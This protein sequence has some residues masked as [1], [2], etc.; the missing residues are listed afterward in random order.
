MFDKAKCLTEEPYLP[1]YDDINWNTL[2]EFID[3]GFQGFQ[4]FTTYFSKRIQKNSA[5]LDL[6]K[7]IYGDN[8]SITAKRISSDNAYTTCNDINYS[9]ALPCNLRLF[10][11]A[12]H[13]KKSK[14]YTT[15]EC[16]Y[17][18]KRT[19]FNESGAFHYKID[20][21]GIPPAFSKVNVKK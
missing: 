21:V 20:N 14:Y 15:N 17:Y 2:K 9:F 11:I 8:T 5:M 13:S 19:G 18:P 12:L 7:K 1:F 4:G 3:D 6:F 16:G 10:H